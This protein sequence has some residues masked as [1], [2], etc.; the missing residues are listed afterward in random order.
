MGGTF[1]WKARRTVLSVLFVTWI[2]S[3]MDR[4]VLSVAMPYI[5]ADYH[6]TPLEMGVVMSAFFAS[7]S[8][9]QIPGGLLADMFGVRRI[10]T[11]AM[12][13]WS[14]FTAITGAAANLTQMLIARVCFGLGEGMFPAAALKTIAVWFPRKERATA[15]AVMLASN[16][17]GAAL[18]PLF[19]VPIVAL[20]GWRTVF[21]CLFLPGILI[22]L[23][24]WKY[25]PDKPSQSSRV[26]PKELAEIEETEAAGSVPESQ[27]KMA[28]LE[29]IRRPNVLKYF[30]ILFT[31]EIAFYGFMTWLPTYLVK[32]RGFSMTQMGVAASL[33]YFAGAIGCVF[34]GWVSDKYFSHDRRLPIAATELISALLLYLA[35]TTHSAGMLVLYQTLAGFFLTLFF[36]TF[37][38]LP[39]N[40]VPKQLMGVTGGF[41]NTAGQIAAF[42]SPVAIGYVVGSSAGRFD[43]AFILLIASLLVSCAIVFLLPRHSRSYQAEALQT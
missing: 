33:P 14:V 34:G 16:S 7:Y 10:A 19:V 4:M 43:G 32:A 37:W 17:I 23:L 24:F 21:Y 13:W 3:W 2:V 18:A 35:F 11:I 12:L 6:L 31:F 27:T 15:N 25:V 36:S 42:G 5:A 20:W 38:A 39:M 22:A 1:Q 8:V 26:S 29:M 40:T 28:I 41:I 30:F 9:S